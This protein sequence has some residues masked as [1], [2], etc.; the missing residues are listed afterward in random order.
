MTCLSSTGLSRN[1]HPIVSGTWSGSWSPSLMTQI[2]RPKISTLPLSISYWQTVRLR[3]RSSPIFSPVADTRLATLDPF[4]YQTHINYHETSSPSLPSH[5]ESDGSDFSR[6]W[7]LFIL[8][9]IAFFS[10]DC[11]LQSRSLYRWVRWAIWDNSLV[12]RLSR[13]SQ[14]LTVLSNSL[15]IY[16]DSSTLTLW[17]QSFLELFVGM[18]PY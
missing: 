14:S 2:Q 10:S 17:E 16:L 9:F 3:I 1:C 7:M 5:L 11:I 13:C 6:D 12:C 18:K 15:H 4:I 8:T